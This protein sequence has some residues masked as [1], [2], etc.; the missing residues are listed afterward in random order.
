MVERGCKRSWSELVCRYA[1]L[2]RC[3]RKPSVFS[4]RQL[5]TKVR[6]L[7]MSS[8]EVLRAMSAKEL[9]YGVRVGSAQSARFAICFPPHNRHGH[10]AALHNCTLKVE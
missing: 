5:P 10:A 6:V 4:L 1:I 9:Q 3:L 8:T 2:L 7:R